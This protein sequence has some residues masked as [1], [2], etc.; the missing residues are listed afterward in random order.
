MDLENVTAAIGGTV[1]ASRLARGW[2]LDRLAGTAGVSRR[3]LIQ[4]EKGQTNPTLASLLALS[5]ALGIGLPQLLA[6]TREPS[7]EVTRRDEAPVLWRGK[8]GGSAKLVAGTAPPKVVELWDWTLGPG[9]SY[10]GGP[11]PAGTRE[12]IQ[13]RQ[14][15]VR[16][17]LGEETEILNTGDSAS[18]TGTIAHTYAWNQPDKQA[19]AQTR[20]A[21]FTLVV[22]EPIVG[23]EDRDE[24]S[25]TLNDPSSCWSKDVGPINYP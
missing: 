5:D 9:D 18:F 11:H 10:E 21:R 19:T 24:L 23:Q 3:L 7:L 22:F 15:A 12:L 4:V 20:T 14:G 13:V 16:L 25:G 6:V 2:S 1:R 8:A 17:V